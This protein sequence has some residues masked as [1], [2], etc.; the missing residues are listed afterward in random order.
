M[1]GEWRCVYLA[2]QF[3]LSMPEV[4][5]SHRSRQSQSGGAAQRGFGGPQHLQ[6][7]GVNATRNLERFRAAIDR[8]QAQKRGNNG[9]QRLGIAGDGGKPKVVWRLEHNTNLV[10]GMEAVKRRT[11]AAPFTGGQP[12]HGES[13]EA[14]PY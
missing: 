14:S 3:L 11:C 7:G 10:A 9:L 2:A 12:V 8:Q 6:N 13:T 4:P 1:S 5:L